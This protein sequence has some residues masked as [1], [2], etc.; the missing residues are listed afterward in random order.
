MSWFLIRSNKNPVEVGRCLSRIH[1]L[2][3]K[4]NDIS[5]IYAALELRLGIE[6]RLK[7]ILDSHDEIPHRQKKSY[8]LDKLN[9]TVLRY[10]KINDKVA[11][12]TL[13]NNRE[14]CK[15]VLFYTPVREK[16]IK[17]GQRLGAFLHYPIKDVS[18]LRGLL[19]VGL[20]ELEFSNK[21][22]LMGPPLSKRESGSATCD[23]I[24]LLKDPNRVKQVR[25][26]M[27]K[28][29]MIKM[30]VKYLDAIEK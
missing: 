4:K 22:E 11:R 17:I 7:E 9:K 20:S 19:L 6:C 30:E 23:F 26:F 8:E 2:L 1:Q 14:S 13:I 24:T 3:R 15:I 10:L 28:G 5:L 18:L 16:L 25:P 21:G 27:R 12:V 29:T